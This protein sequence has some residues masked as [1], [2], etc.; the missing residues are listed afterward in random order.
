MSA[1]IPHF[2]P[3]SVLES[4]PEMLMLPKGY[5]IFLCV[6]F[7]Q[8]LHYFATVCLTTSLSILTNVRDVIPTGSAQ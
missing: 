3:V 6:D 2:G 1:D 5:F 7:I 4:I 8:M